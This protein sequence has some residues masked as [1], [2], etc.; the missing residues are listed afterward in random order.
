MP[1]TICGGNGHNRRTCP[2]R[3]APPGLAPVPP[4][5]NLDENQGLAP[6]PNNQ[7]ENQNPNPLPNEDP[8][9]GNDEFFNN[10]ILYLEKRARSFMVN[11]NL[12]ELNEESLTFFK[13]CIG[14]QNKQIKIVNVSYTPMCL[15]LVPQNFMVEDKLIQRSSTFIRFIE[16]RSVNIVDVFTGYILFLTPEG[17]AIPSIYSVLSSVK[18]RKF[19][20]SNE[21]RKDINSPFYKIL[22]IVLDPTI[23]KPRTLETLMIFYTNN[24]QE[25]L[26]VDS[27]SNRVPYH[28][29]TYNIVL[30]TKA[31]QALFSTLKMNYLMK[32][33]I[34]LGGLE[35]ENLGSILDLHQ[36]I[37]IP[38][39]DDL[40]LEAAGVP[41]KLF[42]NVT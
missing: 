23:Q 10:T 28:A 13:E 26:I 7:G 21:Y 6:P 38:Q 41:N 25:D 39:H 31:N 5:D 42:T 15:Y 22:N 1:C 8:P 36:D 35:N 12:N 14:I 2:Q 34:R 19:E 37:K 27:T 3:Q 17:Q 11:G 18:P 40:D 29:D 9:P 4:P 24:I 33:M 30:P 20:Y 32:Q 16:P